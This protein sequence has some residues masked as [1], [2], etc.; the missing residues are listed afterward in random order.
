MPFMLKHTVDG[1]TPIN[2]PAAMAHFLNS[3]G[4]VC[5][6]GQVLAASNALKSVEA[7]IYM[8]QF[9]PL[10]SE[11][12]IPRKFDAGAWATRTAYTTMDG[13]AEMVPLAG[14]ADDIPEAGFGTGEE[15]QPVHEFGVAYGFGRKEQIY[16]AK[17]GLTLDATKAM[18]CMQ[19]YHTRLDKL[20]VYGDSSLNLKGLLS[21]G[22]SIPRDHSSVAIDASSSNAEI[23][24]LLTEVAFAPEA[25]TDENC[26]ADTL[27]LP[28][29][30]FQ[31]ISRTVYADAG[32]TDTILE[33]FRKAAPHIKRVV[34]WNRFRAAGIT[35]K[36]AS[37]AN[38]VLGAWKTGD[39]TILR[40][41]IPEPFL[42]LAPQ[43]HGTRTIINCVASIGGVEVIQP[44]AIALVEIPNND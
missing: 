15:D 14:L 3:R 43:M 29:K 32:G 13:Q 18:L 37:A 33:V 25:A 36:G 38:H 16:A 1:G 27:V 42:T 6:D 28:L 30:Q 12:L 17:L 44:K 8:R 4:S 41:Q 34:P 22:T 19:A 24:A 35:P 39:M 23:L 7:A 10:K 11:M 40:Q 21:G 5:D 9:A 20:A 2:S 26:I 31:Y